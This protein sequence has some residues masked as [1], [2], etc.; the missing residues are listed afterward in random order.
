MLSIKKI[1]LLAALPLGLLSC[2]N[3]DPT[4][5]AGRSAGDQ[6]FIGGQFA[7]AV[8]NNIAAQAIKPT[9]MIRN[10]TVLFGR[11]VEPRI[12]FAFNDTRLDDVAKSVLNEQAQWIIAH[13]AVRFRVYGHADKVGS[14]AYNKRLSQR[15]ANAVVAYLIEQGVPKSRLDA[16]ASFGET[17]PIVFTNAP[18][19]ANRRTVTEVFGF[20]RN[21]SG[22]TDAKYLLNVYNTYT[23]EVGPIPQPGGAQ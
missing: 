23:A 11:D 21:S 22:A 5:S 2:A 3:T 1:C 15:R 6:L 14:T 20:V 4:K 8:T 16:V 9:D 19:R 13:P 12:N 18:E 7:S 17:R 10:L